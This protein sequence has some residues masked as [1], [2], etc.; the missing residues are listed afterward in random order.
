MRE[1]VRRWLRLPNHGSGWLMLAMGIVFALCLPLFLIAGNV[2]YITNSDWLYSYGWWRNSATD[3]TG[4][5]ISEL[6]DAADQIKDYFNDDA[7]RLDVR[8]ETSR[9]LLTLF[10]EREIL[11]MIDVKALMQ[12]VNSV[13]L[14][15]GVTML[16]T[17]AIGFTVK[18]RSTW[19]YI[20]GWIRWCVLISGI[21]IGVLALAVL[22]NF[23]WVFTQ[24]HLLSFANDLWLLDP[25]QHY[26]LLLFPQRFFMEATLFIGLLTLIEFA[27]AYVAVR[28]MEIR[29]GDS[30][31]GTG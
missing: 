26:L 19:G 17:V 20:A 23:N 6:D 8:I 27:G 2:R 14:W 5:T 7:E 3:R 18:R 29:F 11:H 12:G 9:G 28:L 25:Y 13:G 15:S 1:R 16:F 24:F 31:N 4:L 10:T 22:I 21:L 30:M